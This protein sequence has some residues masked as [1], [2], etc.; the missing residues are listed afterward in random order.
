MVRLATDVGFRVF[1]VDHRAAYLSEDRFPDAWRFLHA[2]DSTSM[3]DLPCGEQSF[4][5]VKTHSLLRDGDWVRSLVSIPLRYVGLLGPRDRR[6]EILA[7][8]SKEERRSVYGPVGL[9][10]GAEGPE[11]V[12][13]SIVAELLGVVSGRAPGHLR[14][15]TRSIHVEPDDER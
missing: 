15:S 13:L 6:Q 9:D 10:V 14:D 4:A 3:A 8:L 5:V 2:R 1:V 7:E 11:Q 12:A